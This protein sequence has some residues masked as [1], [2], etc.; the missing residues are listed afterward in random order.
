VSPVNEQNLL[1]ELVRTSTKTAEQV[2]AL[3]DSLL[4]EHG[5]IGRL[6]DHVERL[7]DKD[8]ERR[9]EIGE[10]RKD[11]QRAVDQISS[12]VQTSAGKSRT[13]RDKIAG[14]KEL[15]VFLVLLAGAVAS[16]VEIAK[17]LR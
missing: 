17:A 6:N 8:K 5:H 9:T 11:F 3:H 16:G 7:Y 4:G 13:L 2:T 10:L 15:V 14:A 1:V 12:A